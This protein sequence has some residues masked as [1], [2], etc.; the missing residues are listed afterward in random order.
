MFNRENQ[1]ILILEWHKEILCEFRVFFGETSVEPVNHRKVGVFYRQLSLWPIGTFLG[2]KILFV[3][4]E[5]FRQ[6]WDCSYQSIAEVM[7]ISIQLIVFIQ[8]PK[9]NP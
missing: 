5:K 3:T 9:N 7:I 6:Q 2:R 1:K 4:L 8:V